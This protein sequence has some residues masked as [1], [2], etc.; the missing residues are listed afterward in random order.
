M[1]IFTKYVSK[2][3]LIFSGVLFLLNSAI[4]QVPQKFNY[5][6]VIRNNKGEIIANTDVGVRISIL[7]NDQIAVYEEELQIKTNAFGLI[8]L[9]IGNEG[10]EFSSINWSDGSY[11]LKLEIDEE[12]GYN[13]KHIGT[14]SF[15]SVPYALSAKKAEN[16]FSGDYND[17]KNIPGDI[18]DGDKDTHLTDDE[19]LAMGYLKN[20]DDADADSK[21]EIQDLSLNSTTNILT[22][23]KNGSATKIDLSKYL[24]TDTKLTDADITNLG[25]IKNADDADSDSNNEI[26]DLSLNTSTNI[27]TITKNGAATE[28]DL[29]KYLDNTDTK[30]TDAEITAMGYVKSSDDADADSNNEIQDLALN[31]SNNILKITKNGLATEIDL[32]KYLD[33]TDTRLTDAEITAMGF[34]KSADDADADVNNEIQD[35]ELN[36]STNILTITKNG[37]ATEVD[38]SKYLD[39]TDTHITDAEISALGFIKNGNDA[40]SDSYNE[41]QDLSLNALTNILTITKNGTATEIDLSKYLDD[42]DTKLTDAD[43][44]A[45]GYVKSTED[46]DA[47]ANNEIQ[48]LNLN[49]ATNILTITKNGSATEIDLNKY[50]DNTDTRLTDA[51]IIAM[52]FVKSSNDADA[53]ANNEIQDLSLN[54]TTNIL[55]I[56]KNGSAS[57]ID[58]S[59]Y[60]NTDT[61]LSDADIASM[62][63]VK[64]SNDADADSA[65]EIQD[66]SL[67]TVT[68]ELTITKN[69]SASKIDLTPYLDNTDTNLSDAEITAMGYIKSAED[70]DFDSNN[71]I[72]DLSLNPVTNILTIT[73]NGLANEIDLSKYLDNTD[74]QNIENV[75]EKG[76]NANLTSIKNLGSVSIGKEEIDESAV[77]DVASTEKG[78]LLPRMTLEQRNKIANPQVGLLVFQID[79]SPGFY[80]YN[81]SD[82]VSMYNTS[83]SG[84]S[85]VD[86][87]LIYTSDGF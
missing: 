35:L 24:N 78:I 27:M 55:T 87:T 79:N 39:D 62:G 22:I 48:D 59:K 71:E 30:L 25:Y 43:I 5:Q 31:E 41:I 16:V 54:S 77:L 75:L 82:W 51:E 50:L 68:H 2:A 69:E 73:K 63:Y 52:G 37:L 4:C 19:I 84:K 21:N 36:E 11:S 3:L 20:A 70:G 14:S 61:K 44:A 53:D 32:S 33:D 81:G 65:N 57:E 64:S 6:A 74:T 29:S 76:D 86:N 1:R 17:L 49:N 80:F 8:N 45:L 47:D 12:G 10:E 34:I 67:N 72:Q 7:Q 66:L 28:V 13:Y 42:T 26:Q 46:A 38:L 18:K 60:L 83:S 56:T 9:Q 58:L 15:L 85:N 40:D 23:T